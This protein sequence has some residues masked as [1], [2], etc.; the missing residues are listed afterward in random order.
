MSKTNFL[1]FEKILLIPKK[2]DFGDFKEFSGNFNGIS[3]KCF[4][5]KNPKS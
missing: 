3:G 2:I 5:I 1:D 4:F